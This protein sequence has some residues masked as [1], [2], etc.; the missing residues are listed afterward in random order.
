MLVSSLWLHGQKKSDQKIDSIKNSFNAF[1]G[2]QQKEHIAQFIRFSNFHQDFDHRP[3]VPYI[4]SLYRWEART[5]DLSL[6]NTIRLGHVNILLAGGKSKEAFQKL[7]EILHNGSELT[8]KDGLSTYTFLFNLYLHYGLY[9]EAWKVTI[10]RGDIIFNTNKV[11]K[12]PFFE[13]FIKI[14]YNELAH[15]YLKTKRYAQAI[16]TF[17]LVLDLAKKEKDYHYIAG[18]HNNIGLV[19]LELKEPQ[20]AH[21]HFKKTLSNWNLYLESRV[22]TNLK[23]PDFPIIVYG[24]IGQAYLQKKKYRQAIPLLKAEANLYENKNKTAYINTLSVLSN[25]YIGLKDYKTAFHLLDEIDSIY[26]SISSLGISPALENRIKINEVLGNYK[27]SYKYLKVLNTITDSIAKVQNSSKAIIMEI[28]YEVAQKNYEIAEQK[29]QIQATQNKLTG[30]KRRKQLFFVFALLMLI[31]IITLVIMGL[32]KRK[33]T[34]ELKEK[35]TQIETRN[36]IIKKALTE[37]ESLLKEVHH[38]V[39]NN[40]Q[41]ISGILELQ[42]VQSNDEKIKKTMSEGQKRLHSMSLIHQKLYEQKDLGNINFKEYLIALVKDINTAFNNPNKAIVYDIQANDIFLDIHIAIP[43]GLIVNE[44]V[45]NA[46]KHAFNTMEEGKITVNLV[47]DDEETYTM[48]V[49]D[50]GIGLSH[51]NVLPKN[52]SLGF[53]LVEGLIRQIEGEYHYVTNEGFQCHINFNTK[54][55]S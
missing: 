3:F 42:A 50:N 54:T 28:A 8:P 53:R 55:T 45:T 43:L 34:R 1:S 4:D 30:E 37:K 9:E 24:N 32:Q 20:K 46:Y 52:N 19:Y 18:A 40:L 23:D 12:D 27:L 49:I 36:N 6:Y 48:S 26:V 11:D 10:K 47:Q 29:S 31:I 33:R 13:N 51:I 16:E 17:K 21:T 39:K 22:D 38:R 7:Q 5:N 25:A 14:H 44:L 35:N 15:V 2:K 41:L